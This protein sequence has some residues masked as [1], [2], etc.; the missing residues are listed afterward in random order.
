MR[1]S[2]CDKQ[3]ENKEASLQRQNAAASGRNLPTAVL[4]QSTGQPAKRSS[5]A[6]FPFDK[7]RDITVK[8]EKDRQTSKQ[9]AGCRR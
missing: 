1:R 4:D 9:E 5:A 6:L 8:G 7:R 3:K 2:V